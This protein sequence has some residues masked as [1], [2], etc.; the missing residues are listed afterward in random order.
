M[1]ARHLYDLGPEAYFRGMYRSSILL[2]TLAMMGRT[3]GQGCSDAGACSAG[4]IGQLQIL[5]DSLPTASEYAHSARLVFSDA[6]GEQNVAITQ[7]IPELDLGLGE[8]WG[9]Q[10]K[11]PYVSTIG[12]LGSTNGVGD[13]TVAA[14]YIFVKEAERRITGT[15]GLRLPTGRTDAGIVENTLVQEIRPLPMPYQTGLGTVDLLAGAEWRYKHYVVAVAYQ[16]VLSQDNKNTF[17]H[18]AWDLDEKAARYF[19]SNGLERMDDAVLRLQ[20]AFVA[21]KVE[22]QPG[23]LGIYHVQPDTRLEQLMDMDPM[24]QRVPVE[25]SQGLTLNGTVDL[26]YKL[27]QRWALELG[28]GMP[29]ITRKERPDGLTRHY[30]LNLGVRFRF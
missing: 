5:Q 25:G 11:V 21:G 29:F 6:V 28:A 26:R 19:E 18:A 22:L 12:D 20:Y 9:V 24:L 1:G 10:V 14:A 27:S 2:I 23:L 8:R 3:L 15:L 7:V 30:V 13:I 17:S 4:P 16:H